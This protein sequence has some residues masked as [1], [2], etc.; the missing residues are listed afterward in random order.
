MLLARE[1]PH[2]TR[3]TGVSAQNLVADKAPQLGLFAPPPR[4]TTALNR[5][6]DAITDRFG[7]RAITTGDIHEAED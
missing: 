2:P 5:A 6:L 3:L 7:A 1:P 4:P